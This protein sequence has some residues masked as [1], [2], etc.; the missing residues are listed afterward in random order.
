MT[1]KE[2]RESRYWSQM[3]L[4]TKLGINVSTVSKWERGRAVPE[5][6]NILRLAQVFQMEPGEIDAI[7]QET[8]AVAPPKTIQLDAIE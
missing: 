3:L 1:L 8:V 2:L 6:F 5:M 7:M 4:A